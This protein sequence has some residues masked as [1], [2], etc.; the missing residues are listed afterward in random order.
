MKLGLAGMGLAAMMGIA[1]MPHALAQTDLA[2]VVAARRDGLKA[3]QASFDAM[4]AVARSGGDPRMVADRIP[5][6]EAWFASFGTR[7]PAGTQQGAPGIDSRAL[8]A[9]WTDRAFFDQAL[10]ALQPRLAALR[11]AAASGQAAD[12]QAALQATGAACVNCHRANRA[13]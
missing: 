5:P 1:L 3:A 13:R 4:V 7:F 8:P 12:F 10:A 6:I 2:A 9:V 11:Q